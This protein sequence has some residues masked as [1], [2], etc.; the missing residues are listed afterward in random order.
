MTAEEASARL[1]SEFGVVL[2]RVKP[3]HSMGALREIAI[4]IYQQ[5]IDEERD[6]KGE[7]DELAIQA[8]PRI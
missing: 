1:C 7:T 5:V 3:E 2:G 4:K 8:I 6:A